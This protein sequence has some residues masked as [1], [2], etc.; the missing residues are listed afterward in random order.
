MTESPT[1]R[2]P[3]GGGYYID[4]KVVD[5]FPELR[6]GDGAASKTH[7]ALLAE[8]GPYLK[9]GETPL[10]RIEREVKDTQSLCELLAAERAKTTKLTAAL[11]PFADLGAMTRGH[12]PV[13]G[14]DICR[15]SIAHADFRNA[16]DVIEAID[17]PVAAL[18]PMFDPIL[19]AA[20]K[21]RYEASLSEEFH[22][23]KHI[24]WNELPGDRRDYWINYAYN[25]RAPWEKGH[26]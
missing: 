16:A 10:Q 3:L 23:N 17:E 14:G 21:R 7:V 12:D 22:P 26:G 11:K 8:C 9:P 19:L 1:I 15:R 2:L 25:V 6:E 24:P 20:A 4:G 5:Q 13:M 18:A